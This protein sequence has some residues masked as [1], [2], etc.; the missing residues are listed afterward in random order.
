M[1]PTLQRAAGAAGAVVAPLW[2]ASE[3]FSWYQDRIP[4][5][6]FNLGITPKDKDWRTQPANHSPLF[7]ADE[8]ALPTGVKAMAGVAIDYLLQAG[9]K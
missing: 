3:D 8:G 5:L 2:T 6:F 7:F 1:A 9:R 4:G